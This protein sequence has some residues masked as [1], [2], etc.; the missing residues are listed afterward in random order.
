MRA[1]QQDL[2]LYARVCLCARVCLSVWDICAPGAWASAKTCQASFTCTHSWALCCSCE[3]D[4]EKEACFI[5]GLLAIKSE[6]QHAIADAGA[7]TGLVRLL[8][9]CADIDLE[10]QVV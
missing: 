10:M 6:H 2:L 8:K 7:L 3:E 4:I 9:R 1:L 5:L